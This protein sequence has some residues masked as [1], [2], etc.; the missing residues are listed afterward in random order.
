ML[1]Q[2]FINELDETFWKC[3]ERD[4]IYMYI[5][6]MNSVKFYERYDIIFYFLSFSNYSNE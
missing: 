4:E 3:H 1:K 5:A 2:K 6:R